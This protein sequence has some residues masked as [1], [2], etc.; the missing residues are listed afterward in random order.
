MVD[1]LMNDACC[2]PSGWAVAAQWPGVVGRRVRQQFVTGQDHLAP[3]ARAHGA[4]VKA[5]N[6]Q[7]MVRTDGS[8]MTNLSIVQPIVLN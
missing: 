5:R 1:G 3:R 6:G 2:H 7:G 4:M 8:L